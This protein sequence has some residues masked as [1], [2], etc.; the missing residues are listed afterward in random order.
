[1]TGRKI[2]ITPPLKE[3]PAYR[4]GIQSP[5]GQFLGIGRGPMAV[6][7]VS[8]VSTMR[9]TA[10]RIGIKGLPGWWHNLV[11]FRGGFLHNGG[12]SLHATRQR[13]TGLSEHATVDNGLAPSAIRADSRRRQE[14]EL[15]PAVGRCRRLARGVS[16]WRLGALGLGS[17][18]PRLAAGPERVSTGRSTD[19]PWPARRER[20]T[21]SSRISKIS[22]NC[23]F[24]AWARPKAGLA[25][26]NASRTASR[27]WSAS[28][29]AERPAD[30]PPAAGAQG[31]GNRP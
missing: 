30:R 3:Y 15:C 4:Q 7:S 11:N 12:V 16:G 29:R 9:Q 6:H 2:A 10:R 17:G 25:G 31:N 27:Q 18:S 19:R 26:S 14:H 24:G 8:L 5:S 20:S 1:M 28:H 23:R 22:S 21:I 13:Q